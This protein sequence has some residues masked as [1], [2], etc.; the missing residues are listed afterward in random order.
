MFSLFGFIYLQSHKNN[1]LESTN[2]ELIEK[3]KQL[4]SAKNALIQVNAN[5]LATI[6]T[7]QKTAK[8][9]QQI[10]EASATTNQLLTNKLVS[11]KAA[12]EKLKEGANNEHIKEW[13]NM[14]IPN[15]VIQ[16]F[17]PP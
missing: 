8:I 6:S 14:H 1:V 15:D 10:I 12:Y 17:N 4:I 9:K 5:N 7:L 13:A 2:S 11:Q 16:L 3:N